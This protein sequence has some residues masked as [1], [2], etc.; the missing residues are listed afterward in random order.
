MP[1]LPFLQNRLYRKKIAVEKLFFVEKDISKLK[2]A[3]L[4]NKRFKAF[5]LLKKN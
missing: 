5:V 1:R 4:N 3:G 2:Q